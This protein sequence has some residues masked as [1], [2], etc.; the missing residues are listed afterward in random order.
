MEKR[1][2]GG[3]LSSLGDSDYLS[4]S[5]RLKSLPG[6][7]PGPGRKAGVGVRGHAPA[8]LKC[9]FSNRPQTSLGEGQ[10]WGCWG[11]G[12]VSGI[13]IWVQVPI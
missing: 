6:S 2:P 7:A 9:K 10:S 4:V 12:P 8:L 13:K 11:A 1:L 5:I 3:M